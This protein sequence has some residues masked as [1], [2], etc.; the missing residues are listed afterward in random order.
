MVSEVETNI[1]AV[2]RL[3]EYTDLDKEAEWDVEETRPKPNWPA[4]GR[5]E[6]KNY[7][8]RYRFKS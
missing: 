2:E 6:F 5:I 3:K 8:S 7:S 1:V 4:E